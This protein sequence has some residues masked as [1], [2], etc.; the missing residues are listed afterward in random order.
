MAVTR[1][2]VMHIA[3]LARLAIGEERVPELVSQLNAILAHM[4]VLQQVDTSGVSVGAAVGLERMP[5][6]E[7]AGPPI[8]LLRPRESFA[9][10]MRDGFFL[11]P[12]LATHEDAE[13]GA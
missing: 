6:R 9:P 7:D 10:E 2:D 3:S 4:E 1:D 13:E 11:V 5:L 12:R 8:P